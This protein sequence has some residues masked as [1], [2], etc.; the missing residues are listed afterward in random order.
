[1]KIC[2]SELQK[3][4]AENFLSVLCYLEYLDIRHFKIDVE[5]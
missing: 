5:F 2:I 4:G 3:R 1:M